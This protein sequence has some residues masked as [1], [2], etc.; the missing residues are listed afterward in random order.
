MSLGGLPSPN[1]DVSADGRRFLVANLT[2]QAT[3]PRLTVVTNWLEA[4]KR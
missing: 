4:L 1:Y 3:A 2:E